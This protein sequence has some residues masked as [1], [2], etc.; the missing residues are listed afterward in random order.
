MVVGSFLGWL[1]VVMA[2]CG[3]R[4]LIFVGGS[5]RCFLFSFGVGFSSPKGQ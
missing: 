2:G 5:L 1:V 4:T 3:C